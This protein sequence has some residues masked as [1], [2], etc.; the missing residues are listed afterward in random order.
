MDEEKGMA[1]SVIELQWARAV[2]EAKAAI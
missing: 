1:S 2:R